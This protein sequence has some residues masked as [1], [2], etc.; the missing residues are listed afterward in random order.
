MVG[1]G[2]ELFAECEKFVLRLSTP[3]YLCNIVNQEWA[4][5]LSNDF[6]DARYIAAPK[7]STMHTWITLA[8]DHSREKIE[9]KKRKKRKKYRYHTINN[10]NMN[11]FWNCYH[12]SGKWK[13]AQSKSISSHHIICFT[14][15]KMKIFEL[16]AEN[17]NIF[18]IKSNAV[19][20]KKKKK[21]ITITLSTDTHLQ[22]LTPT[23]F[24]KEPNCFVICW[25][26][27]E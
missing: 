1:I 7:N 15:M 10:K 8:G 4:R 13:K 21:K 18:N 25:K 2:F 19:W 17:S 22:L 6:I 12:K 24:K 27:D 11:R 9:K 16:L 5:E 3:M 20:S 23:S 14:Q 26:C